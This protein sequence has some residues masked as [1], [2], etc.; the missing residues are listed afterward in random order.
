MEET[1]RKFYMILFRESPRTQASKLS[2]WLLV[3]RRPV[4]EQ[5]STVAHLFCDS[6]KLTAPLGVCLWIR[7]STWAKTQFFVLTL[8]DYCVT[9]SES[10]GVEGKGTWKKNLDS[11]FMFV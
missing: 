3:L 7:I 11:E 6:L 5:F 4:K 1:R 9:H 2:R 10:P 8:R